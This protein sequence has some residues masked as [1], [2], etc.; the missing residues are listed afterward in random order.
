MLYLSGALR[1]VAYLKC[2]TYMCITLIIVSKMLYLYKY[3]NLD[4]II[5]V[6]HQMVTSVFK[7][8]LQIPKGKSETSQR[9]KTDKTM[10][11]RKKG[12]H[13]STWTPLIFEDK[14]RCSGRVSSS[15]STGEKL[16]SDAQNQIKVRN[17]KGQIPR[18]STFTYHGC[19]F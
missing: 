10:A 6:M 14:S 4:T 15:C 9:R 16:F 8:S 3:N 13:W 11:S 2:Y 7:K 19:S 18:N 12:K 17:M 1:W 5:N